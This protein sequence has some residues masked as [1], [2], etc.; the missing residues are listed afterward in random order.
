MSVLHVFDFDDTLIRSDTNIIVN[1][2]DGTKLELNSTE[3]KHYKPES[4]D[5]FDYSEFDKYPF[6]A[7][8]IENVFAELRA[9]VALDGPGSVVI[10]TARQNPEPVKN[11]LKDNDLQGVSVIATGSD[12]PYAKAHYIL[13]RLK[14]EGFN[15]AIVFEDNVKNIRT[16]RKVVTDAGFKLQTNRVTKKMV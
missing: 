6:E 11:F 4:G 16:I 9:A 3:Y 2:K 8:I 5:E 13:G 12:S 14:N 1:K 10:L 7:Q 15:E